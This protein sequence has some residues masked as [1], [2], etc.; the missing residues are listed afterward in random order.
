MSRISESVNIRTWFEK[1]ASFENVSL[2]DVKRAFIDT[3]T[4]EGFK[5]SRH[6]FSEGAVNIEALLGSKLIALL[7]KFIPFGSHLPAGKRFLLKTTIKKGNS[8]DLSLSIIPYMEL[9]NSEEIGGF[10]QPIDERASDEFVA[11]KKVQAILGRLYSALKLELPQD[12]TDFSHTKFAKDTFWG[13]IIYP[14]DAYKSSKTIYSPPTGPAPWC[15]G[16]FII[17]ELWFLWHEIWGVSMIAFMPIAIIMRLNQWGILNLNPEV[18]KMLMITF[19]FII[20]VF[21]GF[22]GNRIYYARYGYYPQEKAFHTTERGPLWCWGSFIIPEFWFLW[23]EMTGV[24][25][26]VIALDVVA[27]WLTSHFFPN[28]SLLIPLLIIRF[29]FALKGNKLY[30]SKY[31]KWPK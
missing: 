10:T 6:S 16:G 22:A 1:E 28:L 9:L 18:I 15:W 3:I 12:L 4:V 13:L 7:F 31:G 20:H 29:A 14:L 26:L 30:Y 27:I 17:P 24:G 11:A 5:I 23:N 21:L 19:I 25:L 8:I 2:E